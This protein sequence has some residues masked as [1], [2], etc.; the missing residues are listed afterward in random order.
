[1]GDPQKVR[2]LLQCK[3]SQPADH[4]LAFEPEPARIVSKKRQRR[5]QPKKFKQYHTGA[6]QAA[7]QDVTELVLKQRERPLM[8]VL[9]GKNSAAAKS[10]AKPI[11]VLEFI[12]SISLSN[13][14]TLPVAT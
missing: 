9:A 12:S 8:V 3:F 11:F 1:M 7:E 10:N 4:V 14:L 5:Q 13:T 2:L 6:N